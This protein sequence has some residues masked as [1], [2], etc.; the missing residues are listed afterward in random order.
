MLNIATWNINSVRLRLPIIRRFL[1]EVAP[2]ILCL[3]EIKCTTD[4]FPRAELRKAGY[5]HIIVNGQKGYH[6]VAIVSRHP[7]ARDWCTG[8]CDVGD[9]RHIAAEMGPAGDGFILHNFYIPA[10]GDTPDPAT[11]PKFAHKLDFLSEFRDFLIEEG[12]KGPVMV[13]GDFNVAPYEN[14]VWSHRQLLKVV[15]HT[16]VETEALEAAR[17]AAGF[18]DVMRQFVPMREKLYTWWSYRARDW[19][20]SDRGRR[21]DHVWVNDALRPR[22]SRL[23]VLSEARG[24]HKPS[25][26][27]PVI[28]TLDAEG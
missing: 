22:V 4:Q 19:R 16:P 7:F 23:H 13:V 25:D 2:D 8:F 12:R 20:K 27:V 14:D 17:R 24:W 26:H 28:A 5:P 18:H 1:A 11:N 6:G 3:Q 10:G 15:S 21:L 9:A